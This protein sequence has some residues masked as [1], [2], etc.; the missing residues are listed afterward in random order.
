MIGRKGWFECPSLGGNHE[1]LVRGWYGEGFSNVV[2]EV[3]ERGV[4]VQPDH[5]WF[6]VVLYRNVELISCRF[7]VE[8][9]S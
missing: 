5:Q 2:T 3:C 6:S 4:G 9:C 7:G 1:F 8:F